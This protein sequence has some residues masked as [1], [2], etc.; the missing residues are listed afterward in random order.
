VSCGNA[1]CRR[2]RSDALMPLLEE[3]S[4]RVWSHLVTDDVTALNC[5]EGRMPA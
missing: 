4:L 3:P 1:D 2:S 5:L